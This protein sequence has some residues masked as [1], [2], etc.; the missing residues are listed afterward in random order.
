MS[1]ATSCISQSRG[2]APV[3]SKAIRTKRSVASDGTSE[4][5]SLRNDFDNVVG[6]CVALLA[7]AE[8]H[9]LGEGD[10]VVRQAQFRDADP[11]RG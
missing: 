4:A 5:L 9:D 2:M 7:D 3:L 1:V 8:L 10:G 11:R 6:S